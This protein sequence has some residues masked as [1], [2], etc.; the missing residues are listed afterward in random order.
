M[1][2]LCA[3]Y[4][5]PSLSSKNRRYVSEHSGKCKWTVWYIIRCFWDGHSL[6]PVVIPRQFKEKKA[7]RAF[8]SAFIPHSSSHTSSYLH[9][10]KTLSHYITWPWRYL[11]T[12]YGRVLS[13]YSHKSVGVTLQHGY[14]YSI[15]ALLAC[16]L[17]TALQLVVYFTVHPSCNK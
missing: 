7:C 3:C 16:S 15:K 8:I 13:K 6:R 10:L 12:I 11:E 9:R 5:T 14:M 17:F 4:Q 1:V 2:V